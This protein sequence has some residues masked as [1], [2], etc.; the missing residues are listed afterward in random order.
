MKAKV[1][2][3]RR[4]ATYACHL[5]GFKLAKFMSDH[6]LEA[7]LIDADQNDWSAKQIVARVLADCCVHDGRFNNFRNVVL[8]GP[9]HTSRRGCGTKTRSCSALA[10]QDVPAVIIDNKRIAEFGF[11][12]LVDV[13]RSIRPRRQLA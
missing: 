2:A 6:G 8:D 11:G 13:Q 12:M 7:I 1:E 3:F 5:R 9:N 4:A 10:H